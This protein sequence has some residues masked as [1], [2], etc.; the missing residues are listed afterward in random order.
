MNSRMEIFLHNPKNQKEV[1]CTLPIT[2]E[3]YTSH[4]ESIGATLI[5]QENINVHSRHSLLMNIPMTGKDVMILNRLAEDIFIKQ[6]DHSELQE[7]VHFMGIKTVAGIHN[8]LVNLEHYH[9]IP[10][11]RNDYEL[12]R[13]L[14]KQTYEQTRPEFEEGY[15]DT[16]KRNPLIKLFYLI[17]G[18]KG[19]DKHLNLSSKY[20]DMVDE[21]IDKKPRDAV[22]QEGAKFREEHSIY[23]F[24]SHGFSYMDK[25]ASLQHSSY[26]W[27]SYD[28]KA[29]PGLMAIDYPNFGFDDVV[30]QEE[31]DCEM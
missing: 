5:E 19:M 18:E 22:A 11:V 3:D 16:L 21:M 15:L 7:A 10:S 27:R 6:P 17:R 24:S 13:M 12:G 29:A 23:A 9:A 28:I 4:L 20:D 25:E 2:F 31:M 26:D 14:I 30:Q 1:S 8:L